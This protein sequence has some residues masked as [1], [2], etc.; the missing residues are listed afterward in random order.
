MK[1]TMNKLIGKND[2][3]KQRLALED[4]VNKPTE[5]D[6]EED[7]GQ[8]EVSRPGNGSCNLCKMI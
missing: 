8:T 5:D 4:A 2:G 3:T 7:P 1:T 6:D